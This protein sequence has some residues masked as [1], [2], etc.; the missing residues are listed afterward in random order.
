MSSSANRRCL[1]IL[2][3][4]APTGTVSKVPPTDGPGC[5]R[6][7]IRCQGQGRCLPQEAVE[8][9]GRAP[10][11]AHRTP[12]NSAIDDRQVPQLMLGRVLCSAF[13][14][15]VESCNFSLVNVPLLTPGI[16]EDLVPIPPVSRVRHFFNLLITQENPEVSAP[17]ASATGHF[18][19]V[20]W[21]IP[22]GHTLLELHNLICHCIGY[23]RI[24]QARS[25][26]VQLCLNL[27]T[28]PVQDAAGNPRLQL[29]LEASGI[30][31]APPGLV[32]SLLFRGE[33]DHPVLVDAGFIAPEVPMP[34]ADG[35]VKLPQHL[36]YIGQETIPLFPVAT[37]AAIAA[38][39]KVELAVREL[40]DNAKV[41]EPAPVRVLQRH[42][43]PLAKCPLHPLEAPQ[44]HCIGAA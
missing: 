7:L 30:S 5:Q 17:D 24:A 10:P 6:I 13:E 25:G 9:P 8:G 27:P 36:W 23:S 37:P 15:D 18:P 21:L 12:G 1:G 14:H 22:S 31:L 38:I 43:P 39:G 41:P 28:S 44:G 4:A 42:I 20:C 32:L 16:A 19:K 33:A 2:S 34:R 29:P 35:Q 40:I 11:F 3:P 26:L